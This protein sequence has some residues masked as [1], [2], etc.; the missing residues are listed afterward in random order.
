MPFL[1]HGP[2]RIRYELD[3]PAGAPVYVL[4]NGLTQYAELWNAYREALVARRFRVA[5]FD[6][7]GQGASDKPALFI[8]QDDQVTAL[9][10]LIGELGDSPI[11]L[12]G[13]SF[14]GLIALRYA[15]EH[16]ERLSGLAPM[17]CFAELSPQLLLLGNA[18]RTGLI[19]GGT[20][21]LQDLL[22]PM[23][24]S[25]HWLKPLLDKLDSV[26]RQGWMVNDLYALQNLMESFLDFQPLTPRLSS[27]AVPT[28][29][30]NGEFDFL[31]PRALH[32]TLRAEIPDSSLVIIPKAYHAFTLEK[33]ALTADLLAR[34]ADDVLAG[35]WQGNKAVWIAPEEAG[36]ELTP[37]PAGY[38]HLRAIP[39]RAAPP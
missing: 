17:S 11:F 3:G 12:S 15:I 4:V 8:S 9:H 29:I 30:L 6:L 14:G 16:G 21:Y 33:G 38:D 37:F 20:G 31:T 1:T 10:L 36:G 27:I 23:N 18:L 13:I 39:V 5:T 28:M 32:E 19:L 34:F 35:R 25:D 2:Y 22:L 24:L 7:L 26:K